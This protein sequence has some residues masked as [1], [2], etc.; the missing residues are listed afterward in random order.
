MQFNRR[1][2][3]AGALGTGVL[4]V[5]P[6]KAIAEE[7]THQQSSSADWLLD[8]S[9]YKAQITHQ[10]GGKE[11]VLSN[12]LLRRVFRLAPNAATVAFDN[13]MT[14]ESVLRSVRPEATL[15]LDDYALSVGGLHGQ[16]VENYFLPEWLDQMTA[17]PRDFQFLRLEE[18]R[19]RARFPWKRVAEWSTEELPWPPPG[20][21]LTFHYGA[22]PQSP[23][24]NVLVR[25]RYELYDGIPLLAKQI[26]VEND[27]SS[28]IV[29]NSFQA[30]ILA[31]V[32]SGVE[33]LS[34]ESDNELLDKV[35]PIHVETD[36]DFGGNMGAAQDNPAVRWKG[37]PS[38]GDRYYEHQTPCLLECAPPVGPE[39]EIASGKT[40]GSFTVFELL[41]D[42]S[43]AERRGL[44]MRKMMTVLAPWIQEN[45]I[46]MHARYAE[47]DKVK[48]VID[49]CA[50]VGF[51]MVILSFGSGF[52]IENTS[53][54]YLKE[55]KELADY[56]KQKGIAIGGY[57]LLASRG[58]RREDL[59]IDV[60]TDR[61]GGGKFGPSPCLGSHWAEDYFKTLRS[62]FPYTGMNVF[63]NDGSYPGDFCAST[64]HPGHKG[65][66]DSQW[67]QWEIM[68]EFYR[69]CRGQGIYLTVP[70]WYFL[71]GQSKTGMGYTENDWSLPREYQ[72]LIERQDI[73][74]GTW[75]KTPSMGWMHVPLMQYHGGGSAATV[76]P[77]HQNLAHYET[78]L[79]DLLGA[80]V[81]AAW[82][83]DRLYDTDETKQAVRKWVSFYKENRAILDS[84][85]I[86][87]RRPDGK[88]WDGIL[89]ANPRLKTRGLAMIYNPLHDEITREIKL[90]LYYTGLTKTAQI[91]IQDGPAK[92]YH[93]ERDYSA[94]VP[95]RI[96]G[97]SRT[98]I[99]V[100]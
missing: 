71:N 1:N 82:R 66:L 87:L 19:T 20:V 97:K 37:D 2:F 22:G 31:I 39:I 21:S 77:L 5:A 92:T 99:T 26:E 7:T 24:K 100:S 94:L 58:G 15:T 46:Y 51:E 12:G 33:K 91:Q 61:P 75:E 25:V 17:A 52:N 38:Y 47:P 63:E 40:W 89:H 45:P 44:A 32:E 78:R 42:S 54:D 59:V 10:D 53:A 3:I 48:L 90:P 72:P 69:W 80:G 70:D 18:G 73:Y 93:L 41:H 8:A 81:Q 30:E 28:P 62:F 83:G 95:V 56:A 84:D 96:D 50:D 55:M 65:Y 14:G 76:E 98:W 86:H 43:D 16:P 23:I 88:D 13:L 57:S 29:L 6:S 9:G 79:A 67:R 64:E 35:L 27:G 74:D 68:S 11:V 34:P 4:S 60:K 36:Y 85:I 49:Q